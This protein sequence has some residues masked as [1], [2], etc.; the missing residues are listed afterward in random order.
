MGF[1]PP[2][3]D[4]LHNHISVRKASEHSGYSEQYLRRMLRTGRIDGLKVGSTWL[5]NMSSIRTHLVQAE[6]AQDRRFGQR[7]PIRQW[8]SNRRCKGVRPE[9]KI[10]LLGIHPWGLISPIRNFNH[11]PVQFGLV[12]D[13]LMN[14][15]FP[16]SPERCSNCAIT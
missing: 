1:T 15:V 2:L 13:G 14:I 6:D 7:S 4:V 16:E 3:N 5:I 10:W 12:R 8:C 11:L 9:I